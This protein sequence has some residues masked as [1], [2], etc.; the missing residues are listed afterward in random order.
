MPSGLVWKASFLSAAHRDTARAARRSGSSSRTRAMCGIH[1]LYSA[2]ADLNRTPIG[3][4][5]ISSPKSQRSIR[6]RGQFFCRFDFHF[7]DFEISILEIS[8]FKIS[9][10]KF[11]IGIL[12]DTH[13]VARREPR[14]LPP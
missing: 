6:S 10:R 13:A 3:F 2:L 5:L 14:I 12:R 7:R 11:L 1:R 4:E 9:I 8:D